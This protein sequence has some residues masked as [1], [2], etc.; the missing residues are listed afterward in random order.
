[1]GLG[2]SENQNGSQVILQVLILSRIG[3]ISVAS[4]SFRSLGLSHR[5][6]LPAVA[7]YSAHC[8]LE[9]L[10]KLVSIYGQSLAIVMLE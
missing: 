4:H 2:L 7:C 3:C 6:L 8:C 5:Y 9:E 10:G 1:M